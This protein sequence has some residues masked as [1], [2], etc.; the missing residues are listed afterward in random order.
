[1][2]NENG[3]TKKP[4]P[5]SSRDRSFVSTVA[6]AIVD[7]LDPQI[8]A[9]AS[10]VDDLKTGVREIRTAV[11]EVRTGRVGI[12]GIQ[13]LV[14]RNGEKLDQILSNTAEVERFL[15]LEARVSALERAR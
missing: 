1:M 15:A 9:M 14:T 10:G 8:S 7:R 11:G 4:K 3:M 12:A 5:L 2:S 6:K 13:T